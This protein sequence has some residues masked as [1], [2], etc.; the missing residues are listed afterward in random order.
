MQP[1]ANVDACH[2]LHAIAIIISECIIVQAIVS[3]L[4]ELAGMRYMPVVTHFVQSQ[5]W[6]GACFH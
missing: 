5:Q 4:S 2:A 3:E 6:C 1:F